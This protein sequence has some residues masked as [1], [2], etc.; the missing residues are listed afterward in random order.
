MFP[1]RD[2]DGRTLGFA[3]LGT[4]L[5]PSWPMWVTSPDAG[6]YQRSE[7]VF[8]IDR[9]AKRIAT[10]KTAVVVGDCVAVLKAHQDGQTNAVTVHTGG[11]TPE[12]ID[13]MA[14]GIRGGA[15][16]LELDLYGVRIESESEAATPERR[17]RL[18]AGGAT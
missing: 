15:D 13:E 9:A 17:G 10:T 16:A 11:V 3:G 14:A 6:L 8:G 12:Q 1:I 18:H 5:G 7:A 2:R 4:H